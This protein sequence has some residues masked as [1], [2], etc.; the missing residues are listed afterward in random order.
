MGSRIAFSTAPSPNTS[1]YTSSV[2]T[3][4]KSLIF[5]LARAHSSRVW[6]PST[7]VCVWMRGLP[8]CGETHTSIT[9]RRVRDGS[10]RVLCVTIAREKHQGIRTAT[11]IMLGWERALQTEAST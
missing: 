11:E 5:L 7:L 3:W 6:V 4:M 8:N 1:P 2:D 10:W 9:T